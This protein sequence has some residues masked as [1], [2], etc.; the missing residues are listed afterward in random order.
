[1]V[2]NFQSI[3]NKVAELAICLDTHKPDTLIGTESWLSEGVS[4]SE[5]F[6]PDYSIIRKDRPPGRKDTSH[7]GVFIAMKCDLIASHRV[8]LD[9]ECEIIWAQLELVGSKSILVGTFYRPPESGSDVLDHL[10]SSLSKIDMS[11]NHSVWLGR[12]FNLSHINWDTQS[13]LPKCPKPGLCRSLID[14][15][16]E[17]S[18]D[19]MVRQPTRGN[20][21][22]DLS[23]TSNSILVE[24]NSCCPRHE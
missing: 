18:L 12:D 10:Q 4:N 14:I 11:K 9:E 1:M 21:I 6:P 24:K 5:I 16:N 7:G 8:D 15:T 23:F 19:Q 13:T 2:I 17:I 3:S 22:L 20:N